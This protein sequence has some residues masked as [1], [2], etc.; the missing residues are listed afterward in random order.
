MYGISP[1]ETKILKDLVKELNEFNSYVRAGASPFGR[2]FT[3]GN[4]FYAFNPTK[5]TDASFY[6]QNI[7]LLGTISEVL[8]ENCI[9]IK[10]Q[11]Y[12]YLRDAICLII[13]RKSLNICM[14]KDIY[15]YISDKHRTK[16]ISIV[17]HSIRN[18]INSAYNTCK[19]KYPDKDCFMNS[20]EKRPTAKMFILRA[21]QEVS[22]RMLKELSV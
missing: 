8:D 3:K 10:N 4:Y 1:S 15:P 6:Q 21:V 9:N 2:E 14:I 20:F 12:T 13:D 22:N 19:N 7:R 11:G 5:D 17:E 18:S 16:S